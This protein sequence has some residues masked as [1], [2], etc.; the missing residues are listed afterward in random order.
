MIELMKYTYLLD[1]QRVELEL[2][3]AWKRYQ[4]ILEKPSW[5]DLNEAR[6]ILY[7]TG[8]IYC[9]QIAPEAIERRLHL[10]K[11]PMTLLDFFSKIDQNSDEL[12]DLRNDHLFLKLEKFYNSVKKFKNRFTNGKYY[13]DEER[14]TK[15][16][17]KY[18]PDKLKI[19][20]MGKFKI[21]KNPGIH[22]GIK[23][24]NEK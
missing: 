10:L 22:K 13:L 18:N 3:K 2:D 12:P 7:L 9:E 6:A 11:Q 1:V 23:R 21:T 24:A 19:G 15:L 8:Q 16:Y 17:N 4:E 20:Y 14:F 5:E